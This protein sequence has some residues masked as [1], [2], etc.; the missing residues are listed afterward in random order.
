MPLTEHGSVTLRHESVIYRSETVTYRSEMD[1]LT[2]SELLAHRLR[3]GCTTDTNWSHYWL[4]ERTGIVTETKWS[5]NDLTETKWCFLAEN[6][7]LAKTKW[8]P[9]PRRSGDLTETKQMY[10]LPKT[11][12]QE[13]PYRNQMVHLTDSEGWKKI[14][15]YETNYRNEVVSLPRRSKMAGKIAEH[16]VVYP[17]R[18]RNGHPYRKR[19]ATETKWPFTEAK[20]FP[21]DTNWS[22][23][24]H[25]TETKRNTYRGE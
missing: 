19:N 12:L 8:L 16:E 13:Q 7:P 21:T 9:L 22:R 5:K 18:K 1:I 23:H 6:E 20:R 25:F 15:E 17:Y 2:E 3:I 10:T 11:K 24:L 4:P 14:A